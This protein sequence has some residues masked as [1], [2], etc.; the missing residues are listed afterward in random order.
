MRL[1]Y[2][3]CR[4]GEGAANEDIFGHAGSLF[5]VIDGAT[6]LFQA[7]LL[8]VRDE[9]AYYVDLLNQRLTAVCAGN[10]EKD[11][12]ALLRQAVAEVYQTINRE[13]K[14]DQAPE[15]LL[16][17]F[18]FIFF[19][20]REEQLEYLALGDCALCVRGKDGPL[21]ITDPR[22]APFSKDDQEKI[23]SFLAVHGDAIVNRQV[24][25]ET[26]KKANTPEGYPIGS[27]RGTGLA[28]AIR[29]A[30]PLPLGV[31]VLAYSDGCMEYFNQHPQCLDRLFDPAPGEIE[32][33]L[34]RMFAFLR[35]QRVYKNNPRP[36]WIDDCTLLL[37]EG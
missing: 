11:L 36:K 23:R 18:A 14:L 25:Q 21:V 12:E 34:S 28:Q 35:D 13:G 15:Y 26:R 10:P 3:M 22:I 33:E 27:V 1:L 32:T 6:D 24:F 29:G 8:G 37:L 20:H 5:W 4:K 7:G 31:R 9:V 30:I 19:R 2:S 16:P 17:N